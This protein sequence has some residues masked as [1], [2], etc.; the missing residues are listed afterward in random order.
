MERVAGKQTLPRV[1]Q[2]ASGNF[3]WIQ[4]AQPRG[5]GGRFRGGICAPVAESW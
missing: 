2:M 3:L 4:G 1:K 5:V